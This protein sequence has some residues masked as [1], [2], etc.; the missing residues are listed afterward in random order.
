MLFF[1]VCSGVFVFFF[2]VGVIKIFGMDVRCV[3][4]IIVARSVITL[5]LV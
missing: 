2:Y 4:C 1:L 5:T 3:Y